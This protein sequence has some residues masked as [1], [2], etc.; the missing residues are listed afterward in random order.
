MDLLII[1][2]GALAL[3]ICILFLALCFVVRK[4]FG[5]MPGKNQDRIITELYGLAESVRYGIRDGSLSAEELRQIMASILSVIAA[6]QGVEY[7]KLEKE[8]SDDVTEE[9]A[10]TYIMCI[11]DEDIIP[12]FLQYSN[13]ELVIKDEVRLQ[14]GKS[15]IYG[16]ISAPQN[17]RLTLL[18]R[19]KEQSAPDWQYIPT[20]QSTSDIVRIPFRIMYPELGWKSGQYP[21]SISLLDGNAEVV[22]DHVSVGFSIP[23]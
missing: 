3:L 14:T 15:H 5:R 13:D 16:I 18:I 6:L 4:L 9:D 20:E 2:A 22:F 1:A 8:F 19:S 21:V 23:N 7:E 10:D 11:T 17:A 12:G